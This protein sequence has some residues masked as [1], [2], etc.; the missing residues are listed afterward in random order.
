MATK[1]TLK[2][3]ANLIQKDIEERIE[4]TSLLLSEINEQIEALEQEQKLLQPK[5]DSLRR[6]DTDIWEIL[7]L[8][9]N[10]TIEA[11]YNNNEREKK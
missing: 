1:K 4:K 9:L 11:V 5:M 10:G 8:Y 6:A 7:E 3:H 2:A